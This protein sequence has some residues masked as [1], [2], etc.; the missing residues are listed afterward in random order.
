M[1]SNR[2]FTVFCFA[3]I[4][5]VVL[6]L[7][8]Q[9]VDQWES[10]GIAIPTNSQ[11]QAP[12]NHGLQSLRP[13]HDPICDGF[14]D[15]SGILLVMKTGASEA[16]EKL[17]THLITILRCLPDF[18]L[19]SDLD[20]NIAGYHVHDS[21]ETVLNTAK[22]DN[23]E[24]DLYR[25]QKDCV[26]DQ[27]MCAKNF[28]GLQGAGWNLDKYK[29]IHIAEKSH[30]LRPG[31]DWYFFVDADTY[32][33]WPNMV[34]ILR[35][36]D[37]KVPW[38]LGSPTMIGGHLFG[39]GGSGYA[40]SSAAMIEFAG[41]H[42]GIANKYDERVK[43]VCCGDYMFATSL[44]ETIGL[45]LKSLWPM[46]NGDKP[47]MFPYGDGHWCQAV[48][49]MHHM[50]SEEVSQFWAFERKRFAQ[51]QK[52][53]LFKEIYHE[54]FEPKLIPMRQDWDNYSD[55]WYYLDQ[56][57]KDHDWEDWRIQRSTNEDRKSELQK[58][59]HLSAEDC[60]RA[61][62]E[63]V[64]CFQWSY[65]NECCAMKKT[66]QLGR[67]IKRPKEDKERMTSGWPVTKID[68]W[69]E[70]QG[71]CKQVHWPTVY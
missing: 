65:K 63:H 59:A 51:T 44:K 70:K 38:Y 24:F 35:K 52:P 49:T 16:F 2:L 17:P 4:S 50:S 45:E 3:I 22:D 14:P 67:P 41:Q 25:Q 11:H 7:T 18:L 32:V 71:E 36:L 60:A 53:L 37:P 68:R 47:S 33:S 55:G 64:E 40:V 61:C 48:G 20:Q 21:L 34:Q 23:H 56:G 28:D 54:Y 29:N 42:P 43:D 13:D 57:S 31:Y 62:D 66:F 10:T 5:A 9:H 27:E 69:I 46:T 1:I 30:R 58:L 12:V 26:I 15:T 39:H 8:A 6:L 19:F